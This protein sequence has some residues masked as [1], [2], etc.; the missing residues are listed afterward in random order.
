MKVLQKTVHYLI[1]ASDLFLGGSALFDIKVPQTVEAFKDCG[2]LS[3]FL[4]C[5]GCFIFVFVFAHAFLKYDHMR[6][7]Q[8]P[9][10]S[11]QAEM[12]FL[13]FSTQVKVS[14]STSHFSYASVSPKI[15]LAKNFPFLHAFTSANLLAILATIFSSPLF[16]KM[17]L[18]IR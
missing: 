11:E 3:T 15:K 6:T 9:Q 14:P 5:F 2:N 18:P 12:I 1:N 10:C 7:Q 17:H 8:L 13:H 4:W 16:I